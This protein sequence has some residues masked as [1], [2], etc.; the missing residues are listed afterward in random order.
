M[1][2]PIREKRYIVRGLCADTGDW[3]VLSGSEGFALEDEAEIHAGF[4][5][6]LL[7]CEGSPMFS[8]VRVESEQTIR[9]VNVSLRLLLDD[10]ANRDELTELAKAL[11]SHL[12]P[13]RKANL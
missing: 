1:R 13:R 4:C 9:Y 12:K 2:L 7:Y 8:R 10:P 6:Q 11:A 3:T 5:L